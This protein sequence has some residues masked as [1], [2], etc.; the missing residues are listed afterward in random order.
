MWLPCRNMYLPSTLLFLTPSCVYFLS[1]FFPLFSVSY[2]CHICFLSFIRSVSSICLPPPS[3]PLCVGV[4][5]ACQWS[6]P[7][8]FSFTDWFEALSWSSGGE[9]CWLPA[10]I[11]AG[12]RELWDWVL[13]RGPIQRDTQVPLPFGQCSL[14]VIT[15]LILLL[16]RIYWIAAETI[17][18]EEMNTK[19]FY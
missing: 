3:L 11:W 1:L 5:F 9:V 16:L 8:S 17:C 14:E 18:N 7:F 13:H 12:N 19:S 6:I 10:G 2:Y 15:E 4:F